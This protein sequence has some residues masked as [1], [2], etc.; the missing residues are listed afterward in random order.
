M[1]QPIPVSQIMHSGLLLQCSPET[2]ISEAAARM[3]ENSV[4][5]ILISQDNTVVGIWT[6][7]DALAIN[8][9][10]PDQFSQ[11]V[12][13]VM[14]SPVLS[15][16][17]TMDTAQAAIRL[18]TRTSDMPWLPTKTANPLALFPVQTWP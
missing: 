13:S 16:P 5:S 18:K 11:P 1:G 17:A 15:L 9:A 3:A 8:F 6:E 7:R 4:S 14:R 10:D 2:V 12:R